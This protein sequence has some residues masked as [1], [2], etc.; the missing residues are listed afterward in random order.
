MTLLKCFF[1]V[2]LPLLT[3]LFSL[4]APLAPLPAQAAVQREAL[5]AQAPRDP[6]ASE[7]IWDAFFSGRMKALGVYGA[8]MVMVQDGEIRFAKGYGYADAVS[9]TPMDPSGTVLRAGSI[10]KTVTATAILQLAEQGKLDL[11]ADVND[12]LTA[13]KVPDS[14]P[15]PVTARQ[16]IH[17][18]A[19]FDTRVVGI[20]A[21]SAAEVQPLGAYLAE[22]MPPR[23]LPPGRYR[24]YNDHEVALAG[25]L[26]EVI[27]GLPYDRYIR[28]QIFA[29][30]EMA[31]SSIV[32]PDDQIGRV[33]RGYPVGGGPEDAYPLSYYYL[34]DAPGAGFNA[35]AVDI[36]HYLIAHLQDGRYT[37]SDGTRVHILKEETARMMHQTA[38][39]YHPLLPGQA[40]GFDE[41]FYRGQRYLRKQGGA[42]GMQND[43]LLFLDQG[44]GFYLFTNSDGTA[45][46]NDWEAEVLKSY[47]SGRFQCPS[48]SSLFQRQVR[49]SGTTPG[50]TSR[51]A[52]APP[53][54]PWCRCRPCSTPTF[55]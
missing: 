32:L 10:V 13:F 33:A 54:P 36:G 9:K 45:L 42:P 44:L 19:G 51:S 39:R 41:K 4:L 27:S 31:S 37:R 25:Y 21:P 29:P 18:T 28:E 20:R 26:V 14:F 7:A 52:T 8:V 46:R 30:L 34:N 55:G 24:R 15:E 2:V 35:S 22:H 6:A 48:A 43:M 11:D 3:I 50:F 5:L 47:L 16:L 40:N 17:M 38:F 1:R 12:Y 53:R 23:V 49:S